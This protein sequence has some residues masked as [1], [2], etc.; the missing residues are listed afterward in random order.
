MWMLSSASENSR[1]FDNKVRDFLN[2]IIE[3]T[4]LKFS[5]F[6]SL[7]SSFLFPFVNWSIF[8]LLSL[9]FQ[10]LLYLVEIEVIQ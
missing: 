10:M 5:V 9:F 8:S 1:G 3:K 6:L 2:G 4:N 7:F